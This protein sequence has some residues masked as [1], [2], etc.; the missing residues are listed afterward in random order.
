[1]IVRCCGKL[2]MELE[3]ASLLQVAFPDL[4]GFVRTDAGDEEDER[5]VVW[6]YPHE[7]GWEVIRAVVQE[8]GVQ[9]PLPFIR[10]AGRNA[11]VYVLVLGEL[12]RTVACYRPLKPTLRVSL[13]RVVKPP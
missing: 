11:N 1:M 3:A 10:E 7:G 5:E 8:V 12:L 2:E 4:P 9:E 6:P 13:G